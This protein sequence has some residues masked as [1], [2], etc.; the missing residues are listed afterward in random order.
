MNRFLVGFPVGRATQS[1][2]RTARWGRFFTVAAA[3]LAVA[4]IQAAVI[5]DVRVSQDNPNLGVVNG[6]VNCDIGRTWNGTR[7]LDVIRN[8]YLWR[9]TG[10]GFGTLPGTVRVVGRTVAVATWTDTQIVIDPW[11]PSPQWPVCGLVAVYPRVGS[12]A[13]IGLN[14]VPS[15]WGTIY[16]QCTWWVSHRR[17]QVGL[18]CA[19]YSSPRPL[20]RSWVPQPLDYVIFNTREHVAL[21]ESSTRRSDGSYTLSMSDYNADMRNG[22]PRC[23]STQFDPVRGIVPTAN[24]TG[25]LKATGWKR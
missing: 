25:T 13:S 11:A 1:T 10:R 8:V 12:S 23:F 15:C 20:D 16:Q 7:P 5:T 22:G 21:V 9:I 2:W 14:I 17:W 3:L 24:P 4:S 19:S 18:S 6:V